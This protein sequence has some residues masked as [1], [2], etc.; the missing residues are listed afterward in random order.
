[1]CVSPADFTPR[2]KYYRRNWNVSAVLFRHA[3]AVV[4][5]CEAREVFD[6]FLVVL[7]SRIPLGSLYLQEAVW[8]E[9]AGLELGSL[10]RHHLLPDSCFSQRYYS[11]ALGLGL[12]VQDSEKKEKKTFKPKQKTNKTKKLSRTNRQTPASFQLP[13]QGRVSGLCVRAHRLHNPL[14]IFLISQIC[15]NKTGIVDRLLIIH[16]KTWSPGEFEHTCA[17]QGFGTGF[18]IDSARS[19]KNLEKQ[20]L[21]LKS[22]ECGRKAFVAL[23]L[24]Q[25]LVE[26]FHQSFRLMTVNDDHSLFSQRRLDT[27]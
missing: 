5:V 27:L 15:F 26:F 9:S 3:E 24:L 10:W 18:S 20:T 6:M 16:Q 14:H 13:A 17:E 12:N 8:A 2:C 19:Q 4:C 21:I 25:G 11:A 22:Q 23:A 1:M 7:R